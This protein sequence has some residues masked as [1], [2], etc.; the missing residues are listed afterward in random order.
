M[1][2]IVFF[3]LLLP[4]GLWAQMNESDT[5]KFKA[6]LGLSGFYQGGN[7]QTEIFRA[8]SEINYRPWKQWVFK[9]R[10]SYV[11]QKF[12]GSKADE[13]FLSLNFL[14]FNP[15]RKIYPLVLGFF[16]SNFRREIKMR[17]LYGA[18]V[19][20]QVLNK[21]KNWLKFSLT[22]EYERT[23]FNL[24]QFNRAEYNGNTSINTWRST[25]WINGRYQLF[26]KKLILTHESYYQPS[27][28]RGDN[29]RWRADLGIELPVWKHLNFRFS[30][31]YTQESIVVEGQ[32]EQDDVMSFGF[33][34]K[35]Y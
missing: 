28:E 5:L 32:R 9:T 23:T 17:S 31:L 15:D 21:D 29:Y 25:I 27:L 18:G 13:D 7:V 34:L 33:V 22:S 4:F 2:K 6:D 19:T 1:K 10:N 35:S 24:D 20:F 3:L 30:Y 12:G 11:Y 8:T 26:D 14:Y 16:S